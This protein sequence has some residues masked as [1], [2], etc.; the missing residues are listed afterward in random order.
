MTTL[1]IHPSTDI[2]QQKAFNLA[3]A[4]LQVGPDQPTLLVHP[5]L[6]LLDG[7]L[8]TSIGINDV[9]NLISKLQFH[10]YQSPYQV[11]LILLANMLTEEAQNALLKSLE[12]PGE[13]TRFILTT[14]HE[15]FL[16]PT[17]RSRSQ[18]VYIKESIKLCNTP[19]EQDQAR[20]E[21]FTGMDLVDK[22]LF[23][24]ELVTREKE[25]PGT[26]TDFLKGLT[27]VYREKLIRS[28]KSGDIPAMNQ[29][30]LSLR[31]LSRAQLFI[32]RNT[33]KRITLENLLLQLEVR[34]MGTR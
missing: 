2:Q 22:F 27:D 7:S 23:V 25:H 8:V 30:K 13:T 14:P 26:I 20:I 17:I 5:D 1:I 28:T 29:S 34:I 32:K 18:C 16:L 15:R 9:R 21:E 31:Q 10:P 33:N 6:H 19:Q 24:E 11:G 12:E 4:F 3:G